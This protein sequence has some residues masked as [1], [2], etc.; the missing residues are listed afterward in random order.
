MKKIF[1]GKL[2]FFGFVILGI[3]FKALAKSTLGVQTIFSHASSN[4]G[5]GVGLGV[6]AEYFVHETMGVGVFITRSVFNGSDISQVVSPYGIYFNFHVKN[7]YLGANFGLV[8]NS[9]ARTATDSILA[10]SVTNTTYGGQIGCN[11]PVTDNFS[12]G[13]EIKGSRYNDSPTRLFDWGHLLMN[14]ALQANV[15]F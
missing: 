1:L 4:L 9:P 8:N 15:S 7:F 3:N 11:Y 2:F 14:Y 13:L 12:V 5:N 10:D 6:N